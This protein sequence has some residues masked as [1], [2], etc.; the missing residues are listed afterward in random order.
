MQEQTDTISVSDFKRKPPKSRVKGRPRSGKPKEAKVSS[1]VFK[2]TK[3]NRTI[4]EYYAKT[5]GASITHLINMAITAGRDNKTFENMDLPDPIQVTKAR[6]LLEL[7][8]NEKEI[9]RKAKANAVQ[10]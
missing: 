2:M 9:M 8:E 5:T 4:I 7:W 1:T 10:N 6:R 3:E